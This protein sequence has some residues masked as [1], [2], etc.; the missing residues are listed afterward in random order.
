MLIFKNKI[1]YHK[2][3]K[4]LEKKIERKEG[5]EMS[6]FSEMLN[7]AVIQSGERTELIE[8][9]T[10][11][12][13][14]TLA[15]YRNGE[16]FPQKEEI[17]Q[18][19]LKTVQCSEPKRN[20]I[21]EIWRIK[22]YADIFNSPDAWECIK[23]IRELLCREIKMSHE[24]VPQ[25]K[26]FFPENTI[27]YGTIDVKRHLE[28]VL[29][30]MKKE[31][32]VNIWSNGDL[33]PE[34]SRLEDK[35]IMPCRHIIHLSTEN[36]E[37][38]QMKA[39]CWAF[40][41]ML[42]Q[43]EYR[44]VISYAG[45]GWIE[46]LFM[47]TIFSEHMAVIL[48]RDMQRS[49]V[50]RDPKQ[51]ATLHYYFEEAYRIGKVIAVPVKMSDKGFEPE[52]DAYYLTDKI[53]MD[54]LKK[55]RGVQYVDSSAVSKF[56]EEG[57]YWDVH[58]NSIAVYRT[59]SGKKSALELLLRKEKNQTEWIHLVDSSK[60]GVR[61]GIQVVSWQMQAEKEQ[62]KEQEGYCCRIWLPT[63]MGNTYYEICEI[64]VVKWI[65]Q[66]LKDLKK[67]RD[68]IEMKKQQ[69]IITAA[70]KTVGENKS[71]NI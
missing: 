59:A 7:E 31:S 12:R 65:Y 44:P 42:S 48:M 55:R 38:R 5:I 30:E 19:I 69:E 15:K 50:I 68:V 61:S 51:L 26:L 45:N 14:S 66:V 52:A 13:K 64:Q 56:I 27:L 57:E 53:V 17:V 70:I 71:G 60:F 10:G 67:S 11:I 54:R 47:G 3:V 21:I 23:E 6:E 8:K 28:V 43:P 22:H 33:I 1:W 63:E 37:S 34:L 24:V 16:R 36:K 9:L 46:S 4:F 58:S 35:I 62:K 49:I 18:K 2:K 29:D 20:S 40:S 25:G 32:R 39:V 41:L